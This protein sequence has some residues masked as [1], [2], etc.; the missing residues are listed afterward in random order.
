MIAISSPYYYIALYILYLRNLLNK[1]SN[2]DLEYL[3][4]N[5]YYTS[6]KRAFNMPPLE[7]INNFNINI[8]ATLNAN[9]LAKERKLIPE[10]LEY[11]ENL[12]NNLS[13]KEY[14]KLN[15][16]IYFKFYIYEYY[17]LD[18]PKYF[19]LFDKV[20]KTVMINDFTLDPSVKYYIAIMVII[21]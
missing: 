8:I 13:I 21:Y 7:D 10:F 5:S 18:F 2:E 16:N 12:D 11:I 17:L 1:L 14:L 20:F 3:I 9:E 15:T 6:F 4:F 19:I